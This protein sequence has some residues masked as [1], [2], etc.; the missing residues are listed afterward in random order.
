MRAAGNHQEKEA[1]A[2]EIKVVW[3]LYRFH[4]PHLGGGHHEKEV[5]EG[6]PPRKGWMALRVGPEGE[7]QRRFV[8]PVACLSH[9]LFAELLDEAAAEYGSFISLDLVCSALNHCSVSGLFRHG[10]LISTETFVIML[11]TINNRQSLLR[12][13]LVLHHTLLHQ[14]SA[15]SPPSC[16]YLP[17]PLS[18]SHFST[19]VGAKHRRAQ[20]CSTD[21]STAR[22][23][24]TLSA[25]SIATPSS[26]LA[27]PSIARPGPE[28]HQALCSIDME[29]HCALQCSSRAEKRLA[30][31][32][33]IDA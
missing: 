12:H 10:M 4:M 11:S 20:Q 32:C 9:P 1:A 17:L 31:Q 8:V 3:K 19:T 28:H 16:K 33:S 13:T 5:E 2:G 15:I 7:E 6:K 14:Q 18:L 21:P 22:P 29:H 26:A 30:W 24:S 27:A 25:S 23:G